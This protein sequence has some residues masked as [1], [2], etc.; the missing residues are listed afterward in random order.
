MGPITLSLNPDP[1]DPG[2]MRPITLTPQQISSSLFS[3]LIVFPP[4]LLI[5]Y[6]FS[7]SVPKSGARSAEHGGDRKKRTVCNPQF[8]AGCCYTRRTWRGLVLQKSLQSATRYCLT[9]ASTSSTSPRCNGASTSRGFWSLCPLSSRLSSPSSTVL[10]VELG[11]AATSAQTDPIKP[12]VLSV[13]L[14]LAA[15]FPQIDPIKPTVLSGVARS[16]SRG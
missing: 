6:F 10:S 4:I 14:G 15:T 9:G 1:T 11:L 2:M 3:S 5:A 12:T 8:C 7:K 13:E 16:R